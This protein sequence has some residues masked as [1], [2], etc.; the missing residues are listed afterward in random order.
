MVRSA[1]SALEFLG[2]AVTVV[3]DLACATVTSLVRGVVAV[4]AEAWGVR[5]G[6]ISGAVTLT[7]R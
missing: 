1:F 4:V 7:E 2:C 5:P 6:L 3:I